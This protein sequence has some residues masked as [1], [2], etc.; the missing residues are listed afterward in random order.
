[1]TNEI[2]DILKRSDKVAFYGVPNEDGTSYTYHRMKG[3]TSLSTSKNPKEY[4]RQYVDE[5]SERTDV[6]GYAPSMSFN[7]D[8]ANGNAVHD[9]IIAIYDGEMLGADAVRP[10]VMVDMT[11]ETKNAVCRTFAVIPDSEGD[12]T[13]AYTYSGTFRAAG[14]RQSGTATSAD[15][16]KT[17]T[18][19]SASEYLS[20]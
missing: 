19:N 14:E 12:S 5:D 11:S 9:D 15:G 13:E 2:F 8:R 6:V 1:M 18:F 17:I 4:S 3:F 20:L 10:I 16:W 7:L